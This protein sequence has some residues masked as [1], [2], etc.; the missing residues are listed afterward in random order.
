MLVKQEVLLDAVTAYI[1]VV[2]KQE[3]LALVGENVVVLTTH[4]EGTR[5]R[6]DAGELTV[7][8]VSQSEARL[9]RAQAELTDAEAALASAYAV[10][11]RATGREASA[12][13]LPALPG[14]L[15][16]NL[17]EVLALAAE[18]PALK[19][20]QYNRNAADHVIDTRVAALLPDVNIQ[21]VVRDSEGSSTPSINATDDRA[22]MLQVSIPLYQSGG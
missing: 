5:T 3:S 15:P 16:E 4:L 9:A 21:G 2:E 14:P 8:D 13:R 18:H 19:R 1:D 20:A 22:L 7:T 17:Q 6:Y 12:G 11:V 10:Y